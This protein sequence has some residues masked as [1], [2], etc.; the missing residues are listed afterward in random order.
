Q[1]GVSRWTHPILHYPLHPVILVEGKY[2][3]AF[4]EQALKLLAP[5]K[6]LRVTYLELLQGGDVKGGVDELQKYIKTN[7]SVIKARVKE[8]PVIILLDWDAAKKEQEFRKLVDAKFP[9]KVAVWPDSAFN[10]KLGKAF[11]GIE[12][13]MP[14][15][16][17][18]AADSEAAVLGTKKNGGRTISKDEYGAFKESVFKIVQKGIKE[19]DLKHVKL[20]LQEL[21]QSIP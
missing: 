4:I 14:D 5:Q 15:R 11:H 2:D 6:N 3:H 10:P 20:F 8:A 16:I 12:R 7:S 1:Q 9:F 13:H 18:N 21:L 19:R 17:I